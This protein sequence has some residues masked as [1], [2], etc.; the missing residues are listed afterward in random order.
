MKAIKSQISNLKFQINFNDQNS[1]SQP[2]DYWKIEIWILSFDLAQDGELVEPFV[3][4]FWVLGI[5]ST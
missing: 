4:C 1:K 2:F 5:F 3:V